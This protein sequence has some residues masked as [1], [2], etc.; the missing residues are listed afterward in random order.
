[1]AALGEGAVS[2]DR[3]TPVKVDDLVHAANLLQ[4]RFSCMGGG[5]RHNQ[6]SVNLS[7]VTTE[8]TLEGRGVMQSWHIAAIE[9]TYHI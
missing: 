7:H 8:K 3:G 6:H 2:Y 5:L 1:M 4:K 9:G